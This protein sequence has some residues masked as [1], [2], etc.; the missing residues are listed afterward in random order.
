[1]NSAAFSR[2]GQKIVSATSDGRI[3]VWDAVTGE[4]LHTLEGHKRA[5]R[6]VQFSPDG[7]K[8]LSGSQDKTVRIWDAATGECVQTLEG[9]VS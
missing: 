5:V 9:Q 1:M 8:I 2:D 6:S 4:C 3:C 7:D